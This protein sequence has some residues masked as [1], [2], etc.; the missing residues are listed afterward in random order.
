MYH[1]FQKL[2]PLLLIVFMTSYLTSGCKVVTT[3]GGNEP[4]QVPQ[5]N[6]FIFDNLKGPSTKSV[7]PQRVKTSWKQYSKGSSNRLAILLTDEN[8]N[9]LGL[10]HGLK[11]IGVPFVITTD[12]KQATQHKVIVV[13]PLISGRALQADA[14]KALAAIPRNGG[15]LIGF[16]VLGGGLHEVFGFQDIIS[17]KR[18]KQINFDSASSIS[19]TF[20]DPNEKMIRLER[21]QKSNSYTKP[22]NKPIATYDDGTAA[23]TY[24]N[25]GNGHAYAIGFDFG[26]YIL[27]G[28]NARQETI[29]RSFDNQYEPSVDVLLR[30]LKAAYLQGEPNAV[31]LS[32]VPQGKDVAVLLTHDIDFTKSI[33]N[34]VDYAR[35]E[36]SQNIRGTY[37][38]QTKYIKDFNDDVFFNTEG[39]QYLKEIDALGMEIGSHTIAHSKIF[40]KFPMG[41]G[42]E[43]Y[44]TYQPFVKESFVAYNGTILGELRVSKFLLESQLPGHQVISFRP[45]ELSYPFQLPEALF[46]TGFKYGSSTTANN[47]LTHLP[48]QA[49]YSRE[50]DS[51]LEMFEFPVTIEDEALPKLGDRVPQAI[52]LA[53]KLR[54]YGGSIVILIHPNILG[55]KLDFEKQFVSAV[56]PYAWFG[57]ISDFGNWWTARNKV[58][59]DI[60]STGTKKRLSLKSP[61]VL[62]SI[63]L[64]IPN[65]WQV[66]K[67]E[68]KINYTQHGKQLLVHQVPQSLLI[69]FKH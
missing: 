59:V 49:N 66:E 39:V 40:S 8:S 30:I 47:A 63:G 58:T 23:I 25:I 46:A 4:F 60:D 54:K 20:T 67:T 15:S 19:N 64:T 68:P 62:D 52:A 35:Y 51:E 32:T 55:H 69:T 22:T 53:Q 34:A 3:E 33:K 2:A 57:S 48:Y 56:K 5:K 27:K 36:K 50:T 9:W 12:Y 10:A 41:T 6:I 43:S 37:F 65:G 26:Q 14:L 44:P 21:T 29:A 38:I 18:H 28:Y 42:S 13:Y 7:L 24:R 45:G 61:V 16:N 1:Y 11:S 31:T 17:D